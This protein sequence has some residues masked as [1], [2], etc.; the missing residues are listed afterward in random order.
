MFLT[1]EKRLNIESSLARR[2]KNGIEADKVWKD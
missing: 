1:T 2:F